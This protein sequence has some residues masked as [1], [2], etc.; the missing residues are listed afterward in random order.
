MIFALVLFGNYGLARYQRHQVLMRK[1]R[2]D[3]PEELATSTLNGE[4]ASVV[5]LGERH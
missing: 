2:L 1:E 4:I 3:A 5:S